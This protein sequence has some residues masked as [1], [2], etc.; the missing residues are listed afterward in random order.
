MKKLIIL[1]IT[2]VLLCGCGSRND[3]NADENKDSSGQVS[4]QESEYEFEDQV[5]AICRSY[6]F[7]YPLYDYNYNHLGLSDPNN[8]GR[9]ITTDK[10]NGE[11]DYG[12]Q[13]MTEYFEDPDLT[14]E[15][16][17][18]YR[19]VFEGFAEL[20]SYE[21][22]LDDEDVFA[23]HEADRQLGYCRLYGNYLAV[24]MYT[25]G[26]MDID[27]AYDIMNDI[28]ALIAAE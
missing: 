10:V 19:G 16:Y 21:V 5:I 2:A 13:I 15:A 23:I 27:V 20:S 22:I 18:Q 9:L 1:I 24:I 4:S 25:M 8:V 28:E 6:G 26:N 14:R 3:K 7:D 11:R 17:D 12:F